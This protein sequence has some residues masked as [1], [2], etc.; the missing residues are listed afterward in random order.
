[1]TLGERQVG[2]DFLWCPS[3]CG[4]WGNEEAERCAAEGSAMSQDNIPWTY[5]SAQAKIR[6][7]IKNTSAEHPR[8]KRVY[9]DSN[10]VP[11]FPLDEDLT[12]REQVT[13]SRLRSG[14]HTEIRYWR[15]KIDDEIESEC[16]TCGLAEETMEHIMEDCPAMRNHYPEDWNLHKMTT[17]PRKT[18]EIWQ[19]FLDKINPIDFGQKRRRLDIHH[20]QHTHTTVAA[21]FAKLSRKRTQRNAEG[22]EDAVIL[23]MAFASA[24]FLEVSF[25]FQQQQQQNTLQVVYRQINVFGAVGNS[26]SYSSLLLYCNKDNV[27]PGR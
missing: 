27:L 16:R 10:S 15:I 7:N 25:H 11:K 6:R 13:L 9:C 1:M 14:H 8:C 23:A 22:A 12:R 3:H 19:R 2:I 17:N 20:L 18:L 26:V 21:V 4:L 5:H 24:D